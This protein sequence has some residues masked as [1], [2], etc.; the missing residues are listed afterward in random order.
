MHVLTKPSFVRLSFDYPYDVLLLNS[1]IAAETLIARST[2]VARP[3]PSNST[4]LA[5]IATYTLV[6]R[7]HAGGT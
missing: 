6:C 1:T 7:T 5:S 3:S 2:T 4:F